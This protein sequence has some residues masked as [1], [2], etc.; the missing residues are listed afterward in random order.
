MANSR[1]VSMI[2]SPGVLEETTTNNIS[3]EKSL[4]P[5]DRS[6]SSSIDSNSIQ[7]RNLS[8]QSSLP[9]TTITTTDSELESE[10]DDNPQTGHPKNDINSAEHK[11]RS[12]KHFYKLFKSEITDDM[13]DLI[14]SYVCAYQGKK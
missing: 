2:S 14:D 12:K 3:K 5:P 4:K 1:P 7:N 13:P 11:S 9:Q 8:Q 10:Q 6:S